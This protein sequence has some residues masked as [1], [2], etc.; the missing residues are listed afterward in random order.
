MSQVSFSPRSRLLMTLCFGVL[1]TLMALAGCGATSATAGGS[2]SQPPAATPTF[3]A[4]PAPTATSTPSGSQAAVEIRS[5]GGYGNYAFAPASLTIKA[6]T[7]V[8]WTNATSAP[9]T[10]TTDAGAPATIASDA[11]PTTGGTFSFTFTMPGTY[12]YH[13]SVHPYMTGTIVVTS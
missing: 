9:H 10:V 5:A 4:Q 8:V 13:C 1:V 3:T 12:H 6:G 7:M 2:G 11:I